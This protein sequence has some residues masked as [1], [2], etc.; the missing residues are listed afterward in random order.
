MEAL[1]QKWEGMEC[2]EV[3]SESS[4]PLFRMATSCYEV[5]DAML[6]ARK[7]GLDPDKFPWHEMPIGIVNAL[8]RHFDESWP[9]S[10][11]DLIRLGH[12]RM[13]NIMHIRCYGVTHA[14]RIA[15][16]LKE[17]G[18]CDNWLET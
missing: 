11:S 1:L 2:D 14:R 16:K 5:A 8:T 6:E 10:S 13:L 15:A 18:K 7:T 4:G 9:L 12:N 17:I 3:L